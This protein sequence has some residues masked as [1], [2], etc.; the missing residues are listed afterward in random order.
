MLNNDARLNFAP[1]LQVNVFRV[2]FDQKPNV[3]DF[4]SLFVNA[5]SWLSLSPSFDAPMGTFHK[6]VGRFGLKPK[7]PLIQNQPM[8]KIRCRHPKP[9][10]K[11]FHRQRLFHK[12]RFVFVLHC[13]FRMRYHKH[14]FQKRFQNLSFRG[15]G[16]VFKFRWLLY[17]SPDACVCSKPVPFPLGLLAFMLLHPRVHM[18]GESHD[19]T[20]RQP[21]FDG[22]TGFQWRPKP[23]LGGLWQPFLE[24]RTV[25]IIFHCLCALM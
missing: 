5:C 7:R 24:N 3:G 16:L 12:H 13:L 10:H 21:F 15:T 19:N 9:F 14:R 11:R 22:K 8:Q 4:V 2:R 6:R 23:D 18:F 1:D 25:S 17:A 20:F